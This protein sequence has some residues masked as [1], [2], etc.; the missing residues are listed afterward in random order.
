MNTLNTRK[1]NTRK[2]PGKKSGTSSSDSFERLI[3]IRLID[4]S[5]LIQF[6]YT[7]KTKHG[8]AAGMQLI[9]AEKTYSLSA[10]GYPGLKDLKCPHSDFLKSFQ[11]N[12]A[13]ATSRPRKTSGG[14]MMSRVRRTKR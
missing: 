5:A 7:F 2:K 12:E 14:S 13:P 1:S 9:K 11:S 3:Q 4:G 8:T 10:S 6:F